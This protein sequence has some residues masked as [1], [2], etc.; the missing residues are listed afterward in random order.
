MQDSSSLPHQLV[1]FIS[2]RT[3]SDSLD[4][5]KDH[6][7]LLQAEAEHLLSQWVSVETDPEHQWALMEHQQLLRR[8]RLEGV[9]RVLRAHL[10]LFQEVNDFFF[11]LE[12]TVTELSG[13]HG[14]DHRF[15]PLLSMSQWGDHLDSF[16]GRITSRY[17]IR[18]ARYADLDHLAGIEKQAVQRFRETGYPTWRRLNPCPGSNFMIAF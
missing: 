13:I 5:L 10:D 11:D 7:Q 9:D 18:P 1:E 16:V 8:C 14:V 3:L 17:L 12:A 15:E 2:A 6:P 4:V